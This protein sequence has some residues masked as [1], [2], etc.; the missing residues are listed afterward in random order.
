MQELP[1]EPRRIDARH[2]ITAAGE[3]RLYAR[4]WRHNV[5]LIACLCVIGGAVSFLLPLFAASLAQWQWRGW[6][7]PY[8]MG[9]QGATLIYLLLIC[10]YALLMQLAERRLQR[11]LAAERAASLAVNPVE[12]P[13]ESPAAIRAAEHA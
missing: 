8:Y 9:A 1:A 6:P 2:P 7:L 10:L 4:Y 11:Q 13:V 3:A 12:S 5:A